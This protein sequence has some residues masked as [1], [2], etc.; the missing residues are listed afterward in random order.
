MAV[1]SPLPERGAGS[2]RA[3]VS[4]LERNADER[5]TSGSAQ[6]V[7]TGSNTAGMQH[8]KEECR[9]DVDG[10]AVGESDLEKT[11]ESEF[12]SFLVGVCSILGREGGGGW[13]MW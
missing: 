12:I 4:G 1:V 5:A 2:E 9:T 6:A 3:G 13:D 10:V 8:V 11:G 7:T